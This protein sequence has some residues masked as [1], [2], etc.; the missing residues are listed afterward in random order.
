VKSNLNLLKDAVS[1]NDLK[2]TE[3]YLSNKE[4]CLDIGKVHFNMLF[5]N[6]FNDYK[7]DFILLFLKYNNDNRFQVN[8]DY[9]LKTEMQL[10]KNNSIKVLKVLLKDEG[11][12][13]YFTKYNTYISDYYSFII[14]ENLIEYK[15]DIR[16]FKGSNRD[17]YELI[18]KF[19]TFNSIVDQLKFRDDNIKRIL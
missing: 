12:L 8:S 9:L 7:I 5:G 13:N 19:K 2:L 4:F 14:L 3:D 1:N 10:S 11:V 18:C 15:E 6:N 16:N 17:K